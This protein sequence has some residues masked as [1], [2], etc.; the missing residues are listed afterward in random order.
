MAK[1]YSFHPLAETFPLLDDAELDTLATDIR[2]HGLIEP[3]IIHEDMIL[4]GRNRYCACQKVGVDPAYRP[5]MG[6]DPF[7]FVV[8]AN[9]HRRHLTIEQK[10][11]L[12]AK[13]LQGNPALSDRQV[14]KLT[15]LS[16]NT[17][18]DV[19]HDAEGRGQIDH[20]DTRTDTKGRQQPARKQP[21]VAHDVNGP[22]HG[23]RDDRDHGDHGDH[24]DAATST[25]PAASAPTSSP[26]VSRPAK[27]S[28]R[29]LWEAGSP[30][31]RDV[32][33]Y[34]V[35]EEFFKTTTTEDIFLQIPTDVR[36]KVCSAFLDWLTVDGMLAAM[37]PGF[38]Q[39]LRAKIPTKNKP[40]KSLNL[41]PT[42]S[43]VSGDDAGKPDDR[44][45]DHPGI[46][47][48]KH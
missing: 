22:D 25:P 45:N 37:S 47:P 41:T 19:R 30:V 1:Q 43:T 28:V 17:A 11:D 23:D 26:T 3:I 31:D 27:R 15:G 48:A 33:R 24:D 29:D 10:R 7:A 46:S 20:V 34:L 44:D 36:K 39:E 5:F 38:G 2:E 21:K 12:A 4:D 8:S 32:I 14:G 40:R 42:S 35:L 16:K 13:V 18:A 6:D 9:L